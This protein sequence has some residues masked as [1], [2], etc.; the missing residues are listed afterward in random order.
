MSCIKM[1]RTGR[2]EQ[3]RGVIEN[4]GVVKNLTRSM[5]QVE[6]KRPL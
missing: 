3:E 2:E 4:G 6:V 1:I 5:K